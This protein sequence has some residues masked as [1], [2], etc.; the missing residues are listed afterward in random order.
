MLWRAPHITDTHSFAHIVAGIIDARPSVGQHIRRL[1]FGN[2]FGFSMSDS[3]LMLVVLHVPC[4]EELHLQGAEDLT[5]MSITRLAYHCPR[6]QSLHLET[7]HHITSQSLLSLA[8][9]CHG[10][11]TFG[12]VTHP[13]WPSATFVATLATALPCLDELLIHA[14][15]SS[16]SYGDNTTM[17]EMVLALARLERLTTLIIV[18]SPPLFMQPLLL[19]SSCTTVSSFWPQ[20]TTFRLSECG[21]I[22]D[23]Q[24]ISFLQTHHHLTTLDLMSATFTDRVL[25]VLPTYLPRLA[26]IGIEGNTNITHNGLRRLLSKCEGLHY[27]AL[28]HCGI[29]AK[30]FPELNNDYNDDDNDV[31]CL[32]IGNP[33]HLRHLN[34]HAINRIRHGSWSFL[35]RQQ[36]QQQLV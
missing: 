36:Q 11:R 15:S 8:Q 7:N 3:L 12:L 1:H 2:S 14:G 30:D 20:L 35:P 16:L 18:P 31:D 33:S 25:D 6:L 24:A 4:L 13:H 19:V 10:L 17:T 29:L 28:F 21:Y 32:Q 34:F 9:H 26:W 5:D 27:V 22:T 23:Q